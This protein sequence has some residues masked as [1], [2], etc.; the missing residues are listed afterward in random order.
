MPYCPRCGRW[1]AYERL[2]DESIK[3]HKCGY[4]SR[5]PNP[6]EEK[7]VEQPIIKPYNLPY[8]RDRIYLFMIGAFIVALIGSF[9]GYTARAHGQGSELSFIVIFEFGYVMVICCVWGFYKLAKEVC[10]WFYEPAKKW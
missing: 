5:D 4:D 2:E 7:P 8:I 10:G 6:K 9:L 1:T 3:C